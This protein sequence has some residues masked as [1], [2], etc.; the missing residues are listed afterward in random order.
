[1]PPYRSIVLNGICL[2][3][4]DFGGPGNV[5]L[6]LHEQGGRART[7]EPLAEQITPQW[8]VLAPDQRG[9]GFSDKP[10]DYSRSAYVN[11][12]ATLIDALGVA[13]VVALGHSMGGINAFQLAAWH[14][15]LVRAIIL[16]DIGAVYQA[17][18]PAW[19]RQ[20]P[21]RFSSAQAA[22]EFLQRNG[23]AENIESLCEYEDGWAFRFE[24]EEMAQ[25]Q[26]LLSGNW[27]SDWLASTCPAL[28]MVGHQ[29]SV[30]SLDLAREMAT[31][32]SNTRL[33]EFP[34]AGHRIHDQ[35]PQGFAQ[36]VG[37]FLKS[38]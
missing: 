31:R 4:L 33:V 3:Y 32:R 21:R 12:A 16:E 30:L 17:P 2:A 7:W 20:W 11:D 14:P 23:L 22:V 18:D 38:L 26:Q 13:P 6:A 19:A 5:V 36:A 9:H 15:Q 10:G 1:M 27:W 35:N 25:S 29:S 24:P 28:L 8:R 34:Q 37:G